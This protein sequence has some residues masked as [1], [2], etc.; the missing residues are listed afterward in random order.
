VRHSIGSIER[1]AQSSS[2]TELVP[3]ISEILMQEFSNEMSKSMLDSPAFL[4]PFGENERYDLNQV[5]DSE[6]WFINMSAATNSELDPA[7][8]PLHI[9]YNNLEN[10][11]Y[12]V[13]HN[14]AEDFAIL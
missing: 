11:V 4:H 10:D 6:D 1:Q 13:R 14:G 2:L 3:E 5:T 12:N 7:L 9:S 8:V